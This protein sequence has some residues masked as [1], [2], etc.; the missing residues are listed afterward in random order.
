MAYYV[1]QLQSSNELITNGLDAVL[2]G[3]GVAGLPVGAILSGNSLVARESNVEDV[4]GVVAVVARETLV[5]KAQL[6]K[7]QRGFT[8]GSESVGVSPDT[9]VQLVIADNSEDTERLDALALRVE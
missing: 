4:L 8:S 3:L 7:G 6:A 9:V 2:E 1:R 5:G